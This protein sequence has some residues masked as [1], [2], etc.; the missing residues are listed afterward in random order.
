MP[1]FGSIRQ[2]SRRV[3][4]TMRE[5][6]IGPV[7]VCISSRSAR[8]TACGLPLPADLLRTICYRLFER[9][10]AVRGVS[11]GVLPSFEMQSFSFRW[12]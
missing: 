3:I 2:G 5:L 7:C 8:S 10:G 11:L 12:F 6:L 9:H 1:N 4:R